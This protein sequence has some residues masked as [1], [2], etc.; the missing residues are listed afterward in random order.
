MTAGQCS[1]LGA[2]FVILPRSPPIPW[3]R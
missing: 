2:G 3:P 1:R